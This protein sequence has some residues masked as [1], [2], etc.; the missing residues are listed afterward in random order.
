VRTCCGAKRDPQVSVVALPADAFPER[1]QI[2]A[3]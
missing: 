2:P 1:M 3:E